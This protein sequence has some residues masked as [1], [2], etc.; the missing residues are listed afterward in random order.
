MGG[1]RLPRT[2]VATVLG[3]ITALSSAGYFVI[4]LLEGPGYGGSSDPNA[5]RPPVALDT[6]VEWIALISVMAWVTA[7]A[8][9]I[10]R[11]D[12]DPAGVPE[13][14]AVGRLGE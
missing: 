13:V 12:A 6:T 4:Y 8:L 2:G 14:S 3:V 9:T 11:T 1:S 7:V 5:P 10:W